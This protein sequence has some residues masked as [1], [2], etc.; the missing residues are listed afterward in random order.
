MEQKICITGG[1]GFIGSHFH[2]ELEQSKIVNFD[3]N[4]PLFDYSSKYYKGDIRNPDDYS[5]LNEFRFN[6]IIHLAAVH[7]DFQS[8]YYDTNVNGTKN[9]VEFARKKEIREIVFFSSVAVY[10]KGTSETFESDVPEPNMEYGKSKLEAEH[11]LINWQKENSKNKLI[12]IRPTVVYGE[13]NFGNVFNLIKQIKSGYYFH[14]GSKNIIKSIAYVKNVVSASL[15]VSAKMSSGI[16]IFNYVDYPKLTTYDL[17]KI[18]A[19][20]TSKRLTFVIPEL[21]AYIL[22][23]PLELISRILAISPTISFLR[24]KKFCSPTNFNADKIKKLVKQEF[25]TTEGITETIRWMESIDFIQ[26]KKEWKKQF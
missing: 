22:V 7:F 12:I 24:I 18:V 2:Q 20:K 3:R 9:L 23:S 19:V 15:F 10:G 4:E 1:S 25:S 16:H 17:S 14:I 13:R 6:K 26:A 21:L 8:D 5:V 11:V